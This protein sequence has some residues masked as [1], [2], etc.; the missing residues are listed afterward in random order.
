MEVVAQPDQRHF[1][2]AV[3]ERVDR[4]GRPL[5]H[6]GERGSM[7]I[8]GPRQVEEVRTIV[9]VRHRGLQHLVVDLDENHGP[10]T[11]VASCLI[12]G[13]DEHFTVD[14]A[15][16]LQVLRDGHGD[17]GQQLLRDQKRVLCRRKRER[18]H[19]DPL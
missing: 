18:T 13:L 14:S 12:T 11:D 7:R 10:R 6:P 2:E 17:I 16:N 5:G 3:R 9:D 19:A 4:S 1:R 15:A 8:M